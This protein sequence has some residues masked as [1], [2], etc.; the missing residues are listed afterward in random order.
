MILQQDITFSVIRNS[1]DLSKSELNPTVIPD[2]IFN[3]LRPVFIIR[4]PVF[5]VLSCYVSFSQET[6]VRPGEED[7]ETIT[8]LRLQR[9]VFDCIKENRGVAPIVVDGDDVVWR[10]QEL[11]KAL[12]RALDLDPQGF[13]DRWDAVPK[14]RRSKW[15]IIRHFLATIDASTGVER[16]SP[17]RPDPDL[18]TAFRKWTELYGAEVAGALKETAEKNMPHFEY[19][20]QFK[21]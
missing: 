14:D 20:R 4:N 19:L 18:E 7:W 6:Q 8:D 21:I 12:G 2:H 1:Q 16:T 17:I 3:T 9:L 15:P 11:G 10:T 13:S 5:S